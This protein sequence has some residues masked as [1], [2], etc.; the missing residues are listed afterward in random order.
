M[1]QRRRALPGD[2]HQSATGAIAQSWTNSPSSRACPH[3]VVSAE[4]CLEQSIHSSA[5][6]HVRQRTYALRL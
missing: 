4:R 5:K 1:I 2:I 6:T 3:F